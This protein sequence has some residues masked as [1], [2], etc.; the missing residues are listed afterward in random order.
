MQDKLLN[1]AIGRPRIAKEIAKSIK[2]PYVKSIYSLLGLVKTPAERQA[3]KK[4]ISGEI[5]KEEVDVLHRLVREKNQTIRNENMLQLELLLRLNSTHYKRQIDL[6]VQK[7]SRNLKKPSLEEEQLN[8]LF[9]EA[10]HIGSNVAL[11]GL[12]VHD[13]KIREKVINSFSTIQLRVQQ[14]LNINNTYFGEDAIINQ[15]M[16]E[17]FGSL[18]K[19]VA[20][21][22]INESGHVTMEL[23]NQ[24]QRLIQIEVLFR[25]GHIITQ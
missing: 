5:T 17:I 25:K 3:A 10:L 9:K 4:I 22:F 12:S 6:I 15:E 1:Q 2:N 19:P 7:F 20:T 11:D 21:S 18:P 23:F 14:K 13:K 8:D 16:Q 24:L